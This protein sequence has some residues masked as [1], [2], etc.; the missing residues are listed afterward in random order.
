MDFKMRL[1]RLLIA[2]FL[3]VP[4]LTACSIRKKDEIECGLPDGGKFIL[5]AEYDWVPIARFIP[6][7]AERV[8]KKPWSIAYKKDSESAPSEAPAT[9]TYTGLNPRILRG[10]CASVGKKDGIPIAWLSFLQSDGKWFPRGIIPDEKL[11]LHYY[12]NMPKKEKVLEKIKIV[13][14]RSAIH[15]FSL[16]MPDGDILIHEQALSKDDRGFHYD[17]VFVGVYQSFSMDGGKTWS[18]PIVTANARIFEMGKSQVDQCFVARPIKI[19]G[20]RID[21][22]FPASCQPTAQ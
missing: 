19:N 12:N 5:T 15:Q 2:G 10:V 7:A 22:D 6:H 16:I 3:T 11:T 8:N 17:H 13:G 20:T 1:S 9:V 4:I 18:E 21:P 14:A